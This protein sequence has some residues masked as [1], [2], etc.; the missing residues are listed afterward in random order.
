MEALGLA[1]HEFV[2]SQPSPDRLEAARSFVARKLQ[3][4][5]MSS[6]VTLYGSQG[7]RTLPYFE[8]VE[9]IRER[10]PAGAD[11]PARVFHDYFV[12][13]RISDGFINRLALLPRRLG[14]EVG[15]WRAAGQRPLT[16]ISL[17]YLGGEELL[18]L[19]K[20]PATLADLRVTMLD[21][22]AAAVRHAQH[23]L[24]RI[25]RD[26]AQFAMADPERW[27]QGPSC[28]SDSV[29]VAYA[30]SLL[31]QI[32]SRRAVRLF[33][34]VHRVLRPGG[35]FIMGC[36]AG[37]PP[38]G[39]RMVR[40]CILGHAWPYR[41]ESEWRTLFGASP[42]RNEHITLEW[43]PLGINALIRAEKTD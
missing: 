16:L 18:P 5:A 33:Q 10:R 1:I 7:Q 24:R 41:R 17:Q 37:N 11:V 36:T 30:A 6:P 31:E 32:D 12:H 23:K 2:E 14:H 38:L 15:L 9:Q 35:V 43:E 13:T 29:C 25:F 21:T 26:H 28:R 40:D 3:E 19:V 8:L 42:F 22:T 20:D 39:E 27:L 4:W 34:A